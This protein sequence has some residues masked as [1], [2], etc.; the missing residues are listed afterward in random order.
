[1]AV[2]FSLAWTGIRVRNCC[3][4]LGNRTYLSFSCGRLESLLLDTMGGVTSMP[5]CRCFLHVVDLNPN[6]TSANG[7]LEDT[8]KVEKYLI[9]DE[10]YDQRE[11]TFRKYKQAKLKVS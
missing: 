9:S 3:E 6:S 1:M 11:N 4:I 5:V 10:A 7:W 8:S 2:A